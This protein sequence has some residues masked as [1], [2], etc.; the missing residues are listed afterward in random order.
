M[1]EPAVAFWSGGKDSALALDRVQRAGQYAIAALITTINRDYGRVS[2]HGVRQELVEQQAAALGIHLHKMY[3]DSGGGNES[4]V[5]ALRATLNSFRQQGITA[6]IFGDIFLADLR[7]WREAL[8]AEFGMTGIFPLWKQDTRALA[9]ELV[10]RKFRALTCCIDDAH[11]NE[12][13]VGRALDAGF[14][15]RLPT[16][17]DPCGE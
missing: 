12:S 6:V 7:Q 3:V 2:M 1:A 8:L 15:E 5:A 4:Y 16:K 10:D 17:V 13:E 9:R 14:F 11:L